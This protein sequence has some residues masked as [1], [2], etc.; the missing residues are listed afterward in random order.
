MSKIKLTGSNSG[1]VELDS[2]ADAGNL[3]LQLPTA[4]TALLSNAGNV[5]TGITTFTGVNITD[6][7]TFNGAS[8]N[9]LWDK[10]DNQLEFGD[11]AKLSFG[12]SSDMQLYHDGNHS[13]IDDSGTGNLRL[14]S[15]TLEIQ[16]L[17]GNK[18][19]AIFSSGGGQTLNFNNSTKFVTT[20]TGVIVTGICTATSF[21]GSGEGLTYTS[22]LSHRNIVINGD[23]R[24]A[25]RATSASMSSSGNDIP[26]CDRWNYNRNGPSA[27]VAQ[28]AEAPDGS[29]FKYS[30]KWTNTSPVGSIS[31]GNSLIFLYKIEGQDIRRLGYGHSSGKIATLSFY[32]KGSLAGKVG[33]ACRRDGRVFSANSD[34]TANTWQ[35]HSIVIP[36]DASTG[37]SANDNDNGWQFGICWGAGSNSTSGATN[38]WIN[39]HNAYTAGFTAGQQGAY[40]TTNGSTFQITGV[41]LEI[42]SQATPFEH[43]SISEELSRCERYYQCMK[44]PS[45]TTTGTNE[46]TYGIALAYN[47]NRT[48]WSFNFKTE[49]RTNPTVSMS[50][51]AHLQGLGVVGGWNAA[52]SFVSANNFSKFGG[53]VDLNWSGTPYSVGHAVE[54]RITSDGLLGLDAEL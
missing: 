18:T 23:M 15:G 24:V 20:N 1:Y 39:F 8:Y 30:L 13:Y 33:V 37:F 34:M 32:A 17:A 42:G 19:S 31:A 40:L 26:A 45:S 35:R 22:P 51:L 49:M 44:G 11:N 38:N 47:N 21:S 5:F 14:R 9:V 2:A 6:D 25:Q 27:T 41:Q 4:G 36:V 43:R 48:L 12:A 53:R 50:N 3:T 10:S 16:N 7:I 29:G 54:M 52:S 28:V 46:A